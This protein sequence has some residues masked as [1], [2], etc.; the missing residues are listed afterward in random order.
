MHAAYAGQQPLQ[1]SSPGCRW[2]SWGLHPL[3]LGSQAC[4]GPAPPQA[5]TAG[6]PWGPCGTH[7]AGV[8]D[9]GCVLPCRAMQGRPMLAWCHLGLSAVCTR[10]PR[11]RQQ[12]AE[13]AQPSP[14]GWHSRARRRSRWPFW[15]EGRLLF[16][17]ET[18]CVYWGLLSLA[19]C[20]PGLISNASLHC[21]FLTGCGWEEEVGK[22][23]SWGR[24][25][26]KMRS[27][28]FTTVRSER[29]SCAALQL[30]SWA[31][32]ALSG[33]QIGGHPNGHIMS[34]FSLLC[35]TDGPRAGTT[36]KSTSC[37]WPWHRE[38]DSMECTALH[39]EGS[40]PPPGVCEHGR[41]SIAPPCKGTQGVQGGTL[42][43]AS[44]RTHAVGFST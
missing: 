9:E 15:Q 10:S 19:R 38:C 32:I 34:V 14:V 22:G 39:D 13:T 25:C 40:C 28:T 4:Y 36:A 42:G 16:R 7:P 26:R 29:D 6:S 3:W 31:G 8:G 5:H 35:P 1:V 30:C 33:V 23:W 17:E 37:S 20:L 41:C 2:A 44:Q 12:R 24:T 21:D 18:P 43:L 11:C 27:C